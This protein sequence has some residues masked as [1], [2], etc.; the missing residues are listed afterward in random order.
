MAVQTAILS[1]YVP[2]EETEEAAE[3]LGDDLE[4]ESLGDEDE[5]FD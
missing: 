3:E 4:E 2:E 5:L 1:D